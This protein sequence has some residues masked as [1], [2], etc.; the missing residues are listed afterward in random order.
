MVLATVTLAFLSHGTGDAVT[1]LPPPVAGSP[2][3]AEGAQLR[4]TGLPVHPVSELHHLI[5]STRGCLRAMTQ[6]VKKNE[7]AFFL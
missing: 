2:E 4:W 7:N 3:E 5:G 1:F 6:N